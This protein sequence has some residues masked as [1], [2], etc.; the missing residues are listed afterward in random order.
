M[1]ES[2]SG[3]SH[4]SLDFI[5]KSLEDVRD[6]LIEV[7]RRNGNTARYHAMKKEIQK[8]GWDGILSKYHPDVNINDPAA[9]ALFLLYRFVYSTMDRKA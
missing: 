6:N 8:I 7:N 9:D 1:K 4:R 2:A 3:D 5:L